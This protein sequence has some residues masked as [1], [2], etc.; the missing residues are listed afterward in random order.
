MTRLVCGVEVRFE[1]RLRL[2]KDET[3]WQLWAL[4][5]LMSFKPAPAV[6]DEDGEEMM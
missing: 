2:H 3:S 5:S 6:K 1:V 4:P